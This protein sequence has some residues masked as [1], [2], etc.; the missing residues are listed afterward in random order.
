VLWQAV[1]FTE[2]TNL[3][4]GSSGG[5]ARWSPAE[6]KDFTKQEGLAGDVVNCLCPDHQGN[7]WIGTD[8][9]LNCLT[10]AGN[11]LEMQHEGESLDM[12][13]A[14]FQDREQNVWA[15]T[16][17]GLYRLNRKVFLTYTK[18]QG[19]SHNNVT[20]VL[21][22][23]PGR[24]WIGTQGGGLD[25]MENSVINRLTPTDS[26]DFRQFFNNHVLALNYCAPSNV[27]WI[28]TDFDG[29]MFRYENGRLFHYWS[30][31]GI[32]TL[33][34]P[35]VRVIFEDADA[36][37]LW[38][39]TRESLL[40]ASRNHPFH[41]YTARQGLAGNSIYAIL[42]D[43]HGNIWVGTDN[44]LNQFRD[45]KI[46]TYTTNDGL[47][48]NTVTALYEDDANSLWIGTAGG[49]LNRRK[50]GRFRSYNVRQGLLSSE[51]FEILEDNAGR[52]W[53][54]CGAGIFWVARKDFGALDT[55][56]MS[57][58]PCVA[59]GKDDGLD[60]IDCD[61]AAKPAACKSSDGRLWFATEKG[62]S[63]V[64]PAQVG[65]ASTEP[66]P[67]FIEEVISDRKSF[68]PAEALRL[69]PGRG[70]LE[71][72]FTALSFRAPERSRFKYRLQGVD[73]DWMDAG[74]LRFARYN[75]IYPGRHIFR[76]MA[77]N[78]DGVWN[79]AGAALEFVMLPHFWQTAWF[80]ACAMGG[81]ALLGILLYKAG[82]ERVKAVERLR[83]H[84]AADLH[85]E[86]G[87][88]LGSISLLS[89]K[90]QQESP[91]GEE[92]RKDLASIKRISTQSANSIR[93]IVWFIN[94]DYDTME[95]L[96]LR[97]KDAAQTMLGGMQFEFIG[98]RDGLR[99]ELSLE[100]R[101]NIFRMFKEILGNV[102]SHSK[103]SSV[104]ISISEKIGGWHLVVQDNGVG[105]QADSVRR[106]NGLANLKRRAEK[107]HGQLQIDTCPGAGTTVS[108]HVNHL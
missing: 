59:Y 52:L 4:A 70:D 55:G 60:S 56:R 32:S 97:M 13:Q 75:N 8:G 31:R 100:F 69:P 2:K 19:L 61:S 42:K 92:Q 5:L 34:D 95:D 40:E 29:G 89:Q 79:E 24:L 11:L 57:T 82:L 103:A 96:L 3:W 77:C 99:R 90:I 102:A 33:A 10:S 41:R 15:G 107:L 1:C 72:R 23:P 39:G 50:E 65:P 12:V 108:F 81:A 83:V 35:G 101:R 46:I 16:R 98:P 21:E 63:V 36:R 86:I 66:P 38:V 93:D 64:D 22:G 17:D 87:S 28:G 58:L 18:Q 91:L 45:G 9:G 78:C 54:T 68:A 74:S 94:P 73:P 7:L 37:K 44:G 27:L 51:I 106:G 80:K 62:L 84:I 49:G 67:V 6:E 20:S 85:D 53:M 71:F 30:G 105:F 25:Y 48:H 43:S 47:S 26:A 76:V 88:S 104:R 14:I